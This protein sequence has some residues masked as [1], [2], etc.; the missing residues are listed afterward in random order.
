MSFR[1]ELATVSD[2]LTQPPTQEGGTLPLPRVNRC[3]LT[4]GLCLVLIVVTVLVY[5]RVGGFDFIDLDD[6]E[7][8]YKNRHVVTGLNRS[9][10]AW[11]FGIHGPGQWHPL[12]WLSHQLVCTAF[13]LDAGAHHVVNLAFHVAS[14]VVLLLA[15]KRLT[16]A[17]WPSAFVAA[18]FA[19]H[20]LPGESVA[21]VCERRDVM[22]G[23][24]WMLTLWAYGA[25]AQRGG[26]GR[27]GL[28]A[29]C[30]VSALMSK[31]MAVTLPCVLLLLDYWPLARMGR[32]AS[33]RANPSSLVGKDQPRTRLR[34]VSFLVME[35]V[36]LLALS[37]IAG[38]LT[39]LCHAFAL[40]P[41]EVF[42]LPMRVSTA[43]LAYTSYLRKMVWPVDLAVFYPHRT[44]LTSD[45]FT[46]LFMPAIAAAVVLLFITVSLVVLAKYRRYLIVGWLWYLGTLVP[47][48]GLFQAGDQAMA[49]R[50]SY[51]PLIGIYL[52]I[53]W[54]ARDL[55][56]HIRPWR[57]YL[58][59]TVPIL[60][61]TLTIVTWFQVG[62][63]H[64]SRTL[65]EHALTVT[66]GNY[67]AHQVLGN[68]FAREERWNEAAAHLGQAICIHPQFAQARFNLAVLLEGQGKTDLAEAQYLRAIGIKPDFAKAHN[69]LGILLGQQ[70]QME[71]AVAHLEGAL[72]IEPRYA[73]AHNN[74]GYLFERQGNLPR[75]AA[76]F[77]RALELHSG[78]AQFHVNIGLVYAKEGKLIEAVGQLE[79][80][81]AI[82]PDD[83]ET[84]YGLARVFGQLND[85]TNAAAH[86]E[87]T[88]QLNPDFPDAHYNLGVVLARR[89]VWSQALSH[90]HTTVRLD[91]NFAAAHH[92]IGLITLQQ[93][94]PAEATNHFREALR[95]DPSY[96]AARENLRRATQLSEQDG[97]S[98]SND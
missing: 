88:L 2:P 27:Y 68:V 22:C 13:G 91:P 59:V 77:S 75:A 33:D 25:Y 30:L 32:A 3:W 38:V 43:V 82:D 23:L 15:L 19:L 98:L 74:L 78:V 24:F 42:T 97:K 5:A 64:S 55:A 81:I 1:L 40:A 87:C 89:Q 65:F 93:G 10:I 58:G 11:A 34:S 31:P 83:P 72:R 47:V 86:F 44:I 6:N 61:L 28:V 80:A 51:L 29:V 53:A 9:N 67:M 62:Y 96:E 16:G 39:I 95:L 4:A 79:R 70:G 60:L 57:L 85:L 8:V 56:L 21:W 71:R 46:S 84:H 36:P 63:W 66:R 12:A 18:L 14:V 73:E 48:S 50:F 92:N 45:P 35:K 76:H 37:I 20:P 94:K 90:F 17:L 49:D 41:L 54:A 69:N 52:I 26:L 7:H